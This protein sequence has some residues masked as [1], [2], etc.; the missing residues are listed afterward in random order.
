MSGHDH[1]SLAERLEELNDPEHVRRQQKIE[2]FFKSRDELE[3]DIKRVEAGNPSNAKKIKRRRK[4][5][6]ELQATFSAKEN[7]F[8]EMRGDSVEPAK[9]PI[10]P[11]NTHSQPQHPPPPDAK[12][13]NNWDEYELKRLLDKSRM[14]N[15]THEKLASEYGVSRQ[16]ISKQL[17]RANDV[18]RVQPKRATPFDVLT[19]NKWK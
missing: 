5:F 17:K 11:Q 12:V 1:K 7:E 14:P 10:I 6:G 15:M 18:L 16:L 3:E 8:Y 9:Q 19:T 2:A 4:I 13:K